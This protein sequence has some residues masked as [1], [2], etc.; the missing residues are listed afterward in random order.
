MALV[1]KTMKTYKHLYQKI[2]N[3]KNLVL[4][5][6]R[7]RKGKTKRDYVLE[8]Q[9][10]A[11]DSLEQLQSELISMTYKPKPLKTFILRDPK[12]RKISKSDFRDRI[13]HHA[14]FR[15]IEPIFDRGFIHDSYANRKG[16]GNLFALERFEKFV[17]E[18]SENGKAKGIIS[19]N[20]IKGYCLKADIKHYFGEVNHRILIEIIGRKVRD[21]KVIWLIRQ[22]LSNT[23]NSERER[24]HNIFTMCEA[25][26]VVSLIRGNFSFLKRKSPKVCLLEI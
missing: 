7:A 3:W 15:I 21:E 17:K 8:F 1:T 26:I 12:T 14:L 23:A 19:D 6:K 4:A 13:V 22:I 18:V 10:N 20:Q 9:K 5:F 2:Y 24:R 16:K 11:I 25:R